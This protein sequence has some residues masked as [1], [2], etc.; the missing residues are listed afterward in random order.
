MN[1]DLDGLFA[2]MEMRGFREQGGV[3][4]STN[5]TPVKINSMSYPDGALVAWSPRLCACPHPTAGR[6]REGH[7]RFRLHHG[8]QYHQ[9]DGEYSV[10]LCKYANAVFGRDGGRHVHGVH[11]AMR[12]TRAV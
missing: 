2:E 11:G 1:G 8:P 7:S 10:G 12:E 6:P 4:V 5:G 3:R 9:A